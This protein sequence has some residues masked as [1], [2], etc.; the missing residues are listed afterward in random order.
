MMYFQQIHIV[1][2][3]KHTLKNNTKDKDKDIDKDIDIELESKIIF[4]ENLLN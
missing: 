1:V 3:F 2:K 4:R